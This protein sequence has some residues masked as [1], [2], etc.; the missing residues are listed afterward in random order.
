MA[1]QVLKPEGRALIKV[2]QR[3]GFQELTADARRRFQKVK[4]VK[5]DAS[6]ARSAETYLLAGARRMV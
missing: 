2:F 1:S 6:R 4:F 5:P 3:A